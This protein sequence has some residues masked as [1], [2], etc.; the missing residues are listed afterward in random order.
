MRSRTTVRGGSMSA[1][2]SRHL[3]AGLVGGL[4]TLA[5]V[6]ADG[7]R[8]GTG[9]LPF[10]SVGNALSAD[11]AMV[12]DQF[13]ESVAISGDTAV[14]G[15]WLEDN[16]HGLNAG[17]A[18]VYQWT[19]AQWVQ[20][21]KLMAPDGMADD[22][23]GQAVAVYHDLIVIGASLA[24]VNGLS[25]SGAAYVYR[26]HAGVWAYEGKLAAS[27]PAANDRF[28]LAV[29]A[30][31]SGIAIGAPREERQGGMDQGAVYTYFYANSVW[32][33]NAKLVASK[34]GSSDWFGFHL[35][36]EGTILAIGSQ[37]DDTPGG[38]VDA[39]SVYVYNFQNAAW[40]QTQLVRA[41]DGSV[42]ANFGASVAI[43]GDIMAVGAERDT[44][45]G[46]GRTG[47]AYVFA[48][49]SSGQWL[50]QAKLVSTSPAADDFFGSSVGVSG[51]TVIVGAEKADLNGDVD[52]GMVLPYELNGN[53]WI[54]GAAFNTGLRQGN[55][56]FGSDLA[57]ANGL[58]V[59][60][61]PFVDLPDIADAGSAFA[62]AQERDCNSDGFGDVSQ[63]ALGELNDVNGNGIPDMCECFADWDRSGLVSSVDVGA[64]INDWFL[65]QSNG[66]LNAD[67][68]ANGITNS[69]DVSDFVNAYFEG[70]Y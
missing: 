56:F 64:F 69:T 18:Y 3:L 50:Q 62:F 14:V 15:A 46:I 60:S 29:A 32:T 35:D 5:S 2:H 28:G 55:E 38:G 34:P 45:P 33:Q 66:S 22:R 47:S 53:V 59:V 37:N 13:G 36:M 39:G 48:R 70:C 40:V 6:Q 65:D 58:L 61:A 17:S 8:G 10:Q 24:D 16:G 25:N 44:T 11:N 68:N 20:I 19:G 27:D 31:E 9:P 26:R 49:Q 30:G 52:A 54:P 1:P 12:S 67:L 63:I 57:F 42:G 7:P 51:S 23:F 41:L 4:A 21:I 43:N